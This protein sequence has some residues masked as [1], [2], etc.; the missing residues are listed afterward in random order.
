MEIKSEKKSDPY[1]T[2]APP[3]REQHRYTLSFNKV[4]YDL[5]YIYLFDIFGA[6]YKV[7][8]M[9]NAIKSDC[10]NTHISL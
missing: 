5:K 1:H 6:L 2:A 8:I 7:K 9:P 3:G 4:T 10:S